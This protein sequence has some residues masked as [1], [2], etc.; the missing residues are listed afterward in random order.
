MLRTCVHLGRRTSLVRVSSFAIRRYE[1]GNVFRSEGQAPP[2]PS[3]AARRANQ[4]V[5]PRARYGRAPRVRTLRRPITTNTDGI[6]TRSGKSVVSRAFSAMYASQSSS[7]ARREKKVRRGAVSCFATRDVVE[8]ACA[9]RATTSSTPRLCI[10]RGDAR[11]SRDRARH[12]RNATQEATR[13]GT[14]VPGLGWVAPSRFE[15][16]L[17]P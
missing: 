14:L 4:R 2:R 11:S 7:R 3:R 13:P 9:T 17:P 15:L 10:A 6:L 5:A 8:I 16:P 1:H 12:L